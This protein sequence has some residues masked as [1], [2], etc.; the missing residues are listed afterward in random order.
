MELDEIQRLVVTLNQG[1]KLQELGVDQESMFYHN[2]NNTAKNPLLEKYKSMIP[3][4]VIVDKDYNIC[5]EIECDVYEGYLMCSAYTVGE[6]GVMIGRGTR[7]ADKFWQ[8][9][10]SRLNSGNSSTICFDVVEVAD[11]LIKLITEPGV[12]DVDEINKRMRKHF[13]YEY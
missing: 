10:N 8:H 11:F 3:D 2:W 6:L 12:I 7:A 13:E 1:K 4:A 9:L 5:I